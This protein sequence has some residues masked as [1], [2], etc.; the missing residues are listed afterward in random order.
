M[1]LEGFQAALAILPPSVFRTPHGIRCGILCCN[2]IVHC[3]IKREK[4]LEMEELDYLGGL[5]EKFIVHKNTV[6]INDDTFNS[7]QLLAFIYK[8]RLKL[9]ATGLSGTDE[10]ASEMVSTM[11]SLDI[12]IK[13]IKE[14]SLATP[15]ITKRCEGYMADAKLSFDTLLNHFD[16]ISDP[17]QSESSA[18][19]ADSEYKRNLKLAM[20]MNVSENASS[21]SSSSEQVG[22]R[23]EGMTAVYPRDV[24]HHVGLLDTVDVASMRDGCWLTDNVVYAGLNEYVQLHCQVDN[25]IIQ[26]VVD[27]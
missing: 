6:C 11:R 23:I 2:G 15:D 1:A 4:D 25:G 20:L 21:E 8:L 14:S 10:E 13:G 16:S 22:N 17:S 7:C 26:K 27:P 24:V 18:G 19:G 5:L 9:Q 12:I 3:Y